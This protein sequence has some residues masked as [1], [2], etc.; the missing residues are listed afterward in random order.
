MHITLY[1]FSKK[2][3]STKQPTGGKSV[4][5]RLKENTSVLNPVFILK[6]DN[7]HY[8]YCKWDNRFYFVNDIVSVTN[9]ISE[10]H[11]SVDALAS[12][13]ADIG[14][15]SEYIL[16]SAYASDGEIPDMLYPAK[17]HPTITNKIMSTL[18]GNF[19]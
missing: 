17:A 5:V 19:T 8:N 3:N 9:D 12:W 4:N 6:D 10:Y 15:L 13:K 7:F 11:C 1:T 16:R 14:A 2:N 18:N